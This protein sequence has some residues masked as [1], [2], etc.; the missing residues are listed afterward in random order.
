M[1]H[2]LF[3]STIVLFSFF[4]CSDDSDSDDA[5]IVKQ[6][7]NNITVLQPKGHPSNRIE[8]LITYPETV[9]N[10]DSVVITVQAKAL[11]GTLGSRI[12]YDFS[13]PSNGQLVSEKDDI[14]TDNPKIINQEFI[15]EPDAKGEMKIQTSQ[16]IKGS[17]HIIV[18]VI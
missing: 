1:R 3:F 8:Y 16:N 12:H 5:E 14:P 2:L 17:N 4:S 11:T 6:N 10:G 13:N 18:N 15:F 9:A 7:G